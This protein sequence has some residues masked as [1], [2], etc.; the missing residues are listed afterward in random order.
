MAEVHEE[1]SAAVSHTKLHH[2]PHKFSAHLA[3]QISEKA[4]VWQGPGVE[5]DQLFHSHV[6]EAHLI[7]KAMF[8]IAFCL[9]EQKDYEVEHSN[10]LRK[11]AQMAGWLKTYEKGYLPHIC[12]LRQWL[13][14]SFLAS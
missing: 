5:Q 12:I 4:T 1:G 9:L 14:Y 3:Y 13:A 2:L 7:S 6:A 11:K 10:Y 8:T